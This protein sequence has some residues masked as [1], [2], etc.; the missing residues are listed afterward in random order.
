M[1]K[2]KAPG[3]FFSSGRKVGVYPLD[4]L[5][6][7]NPGKRQA[8]FSRATNFFS[9]GQICQT[10]MRR[11]GWRLRSFHASMLIRPAGNSS[12]TGDRRA[13]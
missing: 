8:D 1:P 7:R 6:F 10:R 13:P 4:M 3:G 5:F 11:R 2:S 9:T 12:R